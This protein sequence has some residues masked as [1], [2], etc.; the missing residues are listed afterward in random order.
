VKPY[1]VYKASF[2]YESLAW[3][4]IGHE[5]IGTQSLRGKDE[6]TVGGLYSRDA[7][8]HV[9]L[10]EDGHFHASIKWDCYVGAKR[11]NRYASI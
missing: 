3:I 1:L 10:G 11:D 4:W 7:K 5:L 6:P 2:K 9:G 8:V